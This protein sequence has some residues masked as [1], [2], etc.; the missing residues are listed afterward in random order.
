MQYNVLDKGFVKLIDSIGDDFSIEQAARVSYAKGTRAISQ[1]RGLIRYLMEHHHTSP[2]EMCS[3]IFH[4][5]MPFFVR[6]QWFRH[7]TAHF[8]QLNEISGRYSVIENECFTPT[9]LRDQSKTNKQ[10]SDG[11]RPD[12]DSFIRAME[13]NRKDTFSLYNEMI[14]AGVGRELARIDLPLSTYTEFFWKCDLNN[15][16]HLLKL[17]LPEEAQEEIRVYA[18]AVALSVK[19]ICPISYEAFEDFIL[20]SRSF[21]KE[22]IDCLLG[23]TLTLPPKQMEKLV[24]KTSIEKIDLW[25][26]VCSTI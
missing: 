12:F 2:F 23:K 8:S 4:I 14:E 7:R 20:Y 18:R 25:E 13:D 19:S 26:G 1:T 3:F 6:N 15:I 21:T 16:F 5:K 17:R 10:K 11:A 24:S 22:E 9:V